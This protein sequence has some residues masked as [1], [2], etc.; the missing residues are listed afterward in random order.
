MVPI[1]TKPPGLYW[2]IYCHI[3]FVGQVL[4]KLWDTMHNCSQFCEGSKHSRT[5]PDAGIFYH[6]PW[7]VIGLDK[8]SWS[9]TLCG[10]FYIAAA[11]FGATSAGVSASA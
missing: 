4:D 1:T 5:R 10:M 3:L 7:Q 2:Q 11:I 9:I 6:S 8:T